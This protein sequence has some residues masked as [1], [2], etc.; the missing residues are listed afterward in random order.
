MLALVKL[1]PALLER[2]LSV[3]RLVARQAVGDLSTQQVEERFLPAKDPPSEFRRVNRIER[4]SSDLPFD[5][6]GGLSFSYY[7]PVDAEYLI[8]V[9]MPTGAASFG[10]TIH[11]AVNK[12]E[13]RMPLLAT[14]SGPKPTEAEVSPKPATPAPG[15][16]ERRAPSHRDPSTRKTAKKAPAV[17]RNLDF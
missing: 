16:T 1:S 5:S 13:V 2:Y 11:G 9:N 12:Y 10:E 6:R 4:V 7:F 17:W 14:E 3:A 15:N 8:R